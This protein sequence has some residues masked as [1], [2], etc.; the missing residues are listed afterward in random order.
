MTEETK[1]PTIALRPCGSSQIMAHGYDP[2]TKTLALQFRHGGSVYHY[3]DV[4]LEL[5]DGLR[6]SE[7]A[8]KFFGQHIKAG[9]F[10]FRKITVK[11]HG[12]DAKVSEGGAGSG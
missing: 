3:D 12:E 2:E 9:G 6:L 8:G 4:P 5:Y 10:R 7:S 1:T 11:D